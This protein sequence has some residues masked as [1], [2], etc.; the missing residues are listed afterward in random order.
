M[1]R[2]FDFVSG[3]LPELAIR[4]V[5][6]VSHEPERFMLED[7]SSL[8]RVRGLATIVIRIMGPGAIDEL[9]ASIEL[10]HAWLEGAETY[11]NEVKP[12]LHSLERQR[13]FYEA[14]G[15]A[16]DGDVAGPGDEAG[17][18]EPSQ[19]GSGDG[20][21]N[22]RIDVERL[23]TRNSWLERRRTRAATRVDEAADAEPS[24]RRRVSF[25]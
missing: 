21:R 16:A 17:D 11:P 25:G 4:C 10:V 7:S 8:E 2:R 15:S 24:S 1:E 20:R 6:F 5:V 3:E 22:S 19:G 9:R 13:I 23:R 14:R 12:T 18:A